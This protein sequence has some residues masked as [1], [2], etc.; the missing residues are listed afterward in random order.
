MSSRAPRLPTG[1]RP[2]PRA[3][4]ASDLRITVERESRTAVAVRLVDPHGGALTL[5]LTPGGASALGCILSKLA[6]APAGAS[7]VCCVAADHEP[8]PLPPSRAPLG[9]PTP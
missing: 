6:L 9:T 8:L 4:R 2:A 3:L 7:A 5:T 1:L